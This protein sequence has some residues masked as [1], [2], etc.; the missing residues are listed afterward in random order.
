MEG[1]GLKVL[2]F[3]RKVWTRTK[4]FSPNIRYFVA[5]LRF[6]AIYALFGNLWATKVFPGSKTVFRGQEVHYCMVYIAYY[7]GSNLQI[8]IMRKSDAF[9]AKK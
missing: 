9:V 7:C 5:I 3:H 2:G 8:L 6:V 1:E 4:S